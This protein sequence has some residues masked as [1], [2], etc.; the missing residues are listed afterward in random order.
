MNDHSILET[1]SYAAKTNPYEFKASS[2]L[3]PD[4]DDSNLSMTGIDFD[5]LNQE[6][7]AALRSKFMSDKQHSDGHLDEVDISSAILMSLF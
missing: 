7:L 2:S 4:S 5:E 1:H 3:S 6:D